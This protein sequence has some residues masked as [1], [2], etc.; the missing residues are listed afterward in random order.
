MN[1]GVGP[2]FRMGAEIDAMVAAIQED[3]PGHEIEITDRGAYV[4]VQGKDRLRLTRES[5]ERNLGRP[6]Q[7]REL[8]SLL[9]AFSGRISTA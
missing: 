7:M 6:F 2:V 8:E 5:I 1:D 3:N 9:S 4:R